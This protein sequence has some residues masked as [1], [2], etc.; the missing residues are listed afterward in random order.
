MP[1]TEKLTSY[2]CCKCSACCITRWAEQSDT[3]SRTGNVQVTKVT[4][5]DPSRKESI[6]SCKT[7]VLKSYKLAISTLW[8]INVLVML[9]LLQLSFGKILHHRNQEFG[10]M[11]TDP[12]DLEVGI[13]SL[14]VREPGLEISIFTCLDKRNNMNSEKTFGSTTSFFLPKWFCSLRIES[15]QFFISCWEMWISN[16]FTIWPW[17]GFQACQSLDCN[18]MA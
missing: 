6:W 18:H 15:F 12:P 10:Y 9:E 8:T 5:H 17:F 13:S 3:N 11:K 2:H 16:S 14:L 4:L 7:D 1:G